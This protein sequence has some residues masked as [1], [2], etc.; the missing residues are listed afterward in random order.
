MEKEENDIEDDEYE[1]DFDLE[2]E[3]EFEII[4]KGS[5]NRLIVIFM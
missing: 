5:F 2:A 1:D 3:E 4:D